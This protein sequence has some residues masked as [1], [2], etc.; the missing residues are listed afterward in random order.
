MADEA[1]SPAGESE[2]PAAPHGN[3]KLAIHRDNVMATVLVICLLALCSLGVLSS[4]RPPADWNIL[5]RVADVLAVTVSN[6]VVGHFAL[7]RG[8]K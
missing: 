1:P 6:I 5:N 7:S 8:G 2:R 4:L 3:G